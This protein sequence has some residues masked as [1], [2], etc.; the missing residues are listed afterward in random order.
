MSEAQVGMNLMT[1]A[2]HRTRAA[3]LR[4]QGTARSVEI[5]EGHELAAR[6]IEIRDAR[7]QTAGS[8]F[9]VSSRR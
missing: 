9:V 5:A 4:T 8:V 3:R 2:G 7:T 6:A 1:A